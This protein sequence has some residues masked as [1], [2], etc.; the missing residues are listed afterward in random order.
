MTL[1]QKLRQTRLSKGLSQS[2]VAG[3]CVTRNMLS[4][5]E[6]DLASP[7]MRT[8]EHLA[9]ALGVSVGWLLSDEQTD[10]AMERMRRA[11][12]LFREKN[13]SGC[14][15]LFAQDA[16]EDDETLLLCSIAAGALAGQM[17]MDEK[18]VRAKELAALALEWNRKSL[19]ES[20][21]VQTGAL[22]IL[23]RCAILEKNA[24]EAVERY[25][26]YYIE[27]QSA[28]RY[29]FTMA[30]FHLQ[31][32]HIQAAEREIWSIADL[33]ECSR[34]EYLILRG[35]IAAKREQYENAALYFHQAEELPLG[36][37]LEH[38]LYEGLEVCCRELGDYQQ[39]YLYASKQLSMQ[40][41]RKTGDAP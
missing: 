22:D 23:A 18:I 14:L 17:L 37:M 36:R 34:A 15:A 20:A 39:A 8:L 35:K 32:E 3:D 26:A 27:R 24:D 7:S 6:N 2:Q 41:E 30:R 19:Y 28:V 38:E 13:F 31:Q 40:K 16:P 33:P 1:G 11:R 10:A 9:Q 29:H 5:I 12:T 21:Q 25:K 4:Q